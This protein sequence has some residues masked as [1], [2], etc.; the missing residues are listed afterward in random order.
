[1]GGEIFCR[2]AFVSLLQLLLSA[3]DNGMEQGSTRAAEGAGLLFG[4]GHE[5]PLC[6]WL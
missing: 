6:L 4:V 1:M 3:R 5:F 2:D